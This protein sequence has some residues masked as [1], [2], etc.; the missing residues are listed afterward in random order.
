M[1]NRT[2]NIIAFCL[3]GFVFVIAVL[4]IRDDCLTMDE[5]A[6]LPAGYSYLTQQDMRLNPEPPPLLKDL[7]ALPLLFLKDIEFPSEIPAW[8]D[9]VNG[10]WDSG[11]YFLYETGNPADKM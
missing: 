5:T 9:A 7:A 8:K 3:L 2:A 11:R 4:S 1:S 10:Q 6:H